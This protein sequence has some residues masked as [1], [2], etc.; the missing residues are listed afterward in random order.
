MK[1]IIPVA[2]YATRLYPLTR[3]KPKALIEVK[4]KPILSHIVSRICAIGGITEILVVTNNKFFYQFEDWAKCENSDV[5]I[6]VINDNTVSNE[7]R[8]G[9]MG[10]IQLALEEGKVKDDLLV[11]SG[12]NLFNFPLNGMLADF[13]AKRANL[14]ALYD[15]SDTDEAKKMG[16]VQVDKSMR[17]KAFHEKPE[18]PK[19][20]LCSCGIYFY[21]AKTIARISEY[22]SEG[23]DPDKMGNFLEWLITREAVYGH[24]FLE[25]WFDIGSFESLGR[26]R[27]EFKP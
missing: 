4:G 3:E 12:D 19:S 16:V 7:D 8:L 20:T 22:I 11:V 6:R 5:P 13:R 2:G 27:E 1:A 18:E 17:V 25:K 23:N 21:P 10:D 15:V 14:I 26:A 9:Q 24:I